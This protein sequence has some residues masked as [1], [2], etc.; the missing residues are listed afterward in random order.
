MNSY[1]A[2]KNY[3]RS[4]YIKL[5]DVQHTPVQRYSHYDVLNYYICKM[6]A[7]YQTMKHRG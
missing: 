1:F 7:L 3:N 4:Q 6:F 5:I 2:S